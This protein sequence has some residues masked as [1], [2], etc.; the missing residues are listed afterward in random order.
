MVK[1]ESEQQLIQRAFNGDEDAF[2]QLLWRSYDRLAAHIAPKLPDSL[3]RSVDVEDVLQ[4]TFTHAWRQMR[5]FLPTGS[6]SF[7]LWIRTIAERRLLDKIRAHR[8]AKRGGGRAPAASR[9]SGSSSLAGTLLDLVATDENTPSGSAARRE[10][11]RALFV[12]LAGLK[13]DYQTVLK[14]RYLEG[15]PVERVASRMDRSHAAVHMLSKRAIKKLRKAM[16]SASHYLSQ[17]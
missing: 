15:L 6:S 14:L 1:E 3:R 17:R 5:N 12:A 9:I 8:A 13:D 16:G 2:A 7:Y 4:E 11:E 10:A